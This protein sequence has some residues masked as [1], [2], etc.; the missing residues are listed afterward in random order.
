MSGK[1][2]FAW[3]K[4]RYTVLMGRP[5]EEHELDR[6]MKVKEKLGIDYD[7]PVILQLL[8]LEYYQQLF[9]QVPEKIRVVI[10]QTETHASKVFD[11]KAGEMAE[12]QAAV[13]TSAANEQ[14]K[15]LT[16][17]GNTMITAVGEQAKEK[18]GNVIETEFRQALGP[19]FASASVEVSNANFTIRGFARRY[20]GELFL[21]GVVGG[22]VGS[23]LV[24][25]GVYFFSRP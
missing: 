22:M 21:A 13:V 8:A 20:R 1:K 4:E 19:A 18:V 15:L 5:P 23:A 10:T 14:L 3:L 9:E 25:A 6:L 16:K 2:D 24:L 11:H 7:D 12:R 17:A